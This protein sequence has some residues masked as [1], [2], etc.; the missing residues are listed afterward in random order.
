[1]GDDSPHE[2]ADRTGRDRLILVR[3]VG[4]CWVCVS[5]TRDT[6]GYINV[7]VRQRSHKLHRLIYQVIHGARPRSVVVRHTCD[8]PPCINPAHL[9]EGTQAQNLHDMT[10]RGRRHMPWKTTERQRAEIIAR[11]RGGETMTTLARD[12]GISEAAV[13]LYCR[14]AGLPDGRT[15]LER[16]RLRA[17]RVA[18]E[19]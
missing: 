16:D 17:M 11:R 7:T 14:A 4:A 12:Y 2:P 9:V 8:N 15:K 3:I 5:H 1:M 6:F 10:D 18:Q 13:R 19:P